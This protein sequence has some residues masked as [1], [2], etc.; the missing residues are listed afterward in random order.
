VR[1]TSENAVQAL[2]YRILGK[3]LASDVD[4]A[5]MR[6]GAVED[7]KLDLEHKALL[8][9]HQRREAIQHQLWQEWVRWIESEETE[10]V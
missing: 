8:G 1:V 3:P 9:V 10:K 6:R 7:F 2:V 4:V 5:E